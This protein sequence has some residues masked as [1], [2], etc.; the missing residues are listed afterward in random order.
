MRTWRD[1]A[2][3]FGA[4]SKQGKDVRLALLVA[5]SVD[6]KNRTPNKVTPAVFIKE[7]GL[8]DVGRVTRHLD[9]WDRLAQLKMVPAAWD[10]TPSDVETLA[11]TD[12]AA[13]AFE[14][15]LLRSKTDSDE[16]G[17]QKVQDVK[18][19]VK[20]VARALSDPVFLNKL[21][22]RLD[23]G[24]AAHVASTL[25]PVPAWTPEREAIQRTAQDTE[26]ERAA[27]EEIGEQAKAA[28][29]SEQFLLDVLF[30][31]AELARAE[32]WS[33][34]EQ[35]RDRVLA[36]LDLHAAVDLTPEMFES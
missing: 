11:F 24:L 5:C 12:A 35:I 8:P 30:K 19:N 25:D 10:L 2:H 26:S 31:I 6:R 36:E 14:N 17:A 27:H 16:P 18:S 22:D 7:S 20:A 29:N 1:N 28:L 15:M 33:A 34:L 4:L 9:A 21:R 32:K 3:E 23:P 13:E